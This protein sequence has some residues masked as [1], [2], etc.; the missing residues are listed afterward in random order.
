[1]HTYGVINMKLK[2][3]SQYLK[4]AKG[5]ARE[6]I[7]DLGKISDSIRSPRMEF[8]GVFSAYKAMMPSADETPNAD[9]ELLEN[10]ARRMDGDEQYVP[11]DIVIK[12][13]IQALS[14]CKNE[15]KTI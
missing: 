8:Y 15:N 9:L 6:N 14:G 3:L 13:A 10:I 7:K 4:E 2:D 11:S 5:L 12:F 1:M